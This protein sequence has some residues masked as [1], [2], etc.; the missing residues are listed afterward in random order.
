M[1]ACQTRILLPGVGGQEKLQKLFADFWLVLPARRLLAVGSDS[2]HSDP[3][4]PTLAA[5][6]S[7]LLVWFPPQIAF[8]AVEAVGVV[9]P[10]LLL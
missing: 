1:L 10:Q 6:A 4:F 9:A 5:L 8:A 7:S 2:D 3:F